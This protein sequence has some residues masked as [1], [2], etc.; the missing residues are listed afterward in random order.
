[1]QAVDLYF[2][3]AKECREAARLA[4]SR[5]VK[6]QLSELA[7]T[8]EQLARERLSLLELQTKLKGPPGRRTD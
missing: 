8:W 4:K 1:M 2:R 6:A 5:N 3:R 7:E